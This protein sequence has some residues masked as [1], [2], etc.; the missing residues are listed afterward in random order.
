MIQA[1]VSAAIFNAQRMKKSDRWWTWK[2]FHPEHNT[3]GEAH[4]TGEEINS[5]ITATYENDP[6][7]TLE[8]DP[9]WKR[10]IHGEQQ[11]D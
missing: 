10:D 1:S 4:N 2:D 5:R 3:G 6:N 8:V 11:S 7:V 9:N